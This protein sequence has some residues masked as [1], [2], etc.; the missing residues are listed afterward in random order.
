MEERDSMK[1]ITDE[2]RIERGKRVAKYATGVGLA[3][4]VAGM[5]ISLA[6]QQSSLFWLSLLCLVL[7]L[8]ISSIGTLNM[9]RWVRQPRADEALAQALKGFDDRYRLYN[10][11]LPAPHV[12][13][14]P[15]G[16]YVLTAM[17]QD[18]VVRYEDGKFRRNFSLGRLLRFMADEGLG[19]PFAVAD[20]EVNALQQLL[21]EHDAQEV[22][23]ENIV[24]F[25]NPRAELLAQDTPRPVVVPKALKKL[26]RKQSD[27]DLSNRQ[28]RQLKEILD[29]A[30]G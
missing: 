18:G 1:I 29:D 25:Y 21:A 20:S 14:S 5:V 7:G 4:L 6:F 24:V 26:I 15:V 9:N 3:V 12:L 11:L 8:V 28:Y 17:G 22:E 23:V 16:L 27:S 30:A 2:A 19:R 10:Y 13:L